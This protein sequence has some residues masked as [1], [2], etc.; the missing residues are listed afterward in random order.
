MQWHQLL[1]QGHL[2]V[3]GKRYDLTHLL[4]CVAY[5]WD[6]DKGKAGIP[7]NR[8]GRIKFPVMAAKVLRGEPI[9]D[10]ARNR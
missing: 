2:Q 1:K 3:D 9:R 4:G 6:A 10:P 8:R 7:R 5:V